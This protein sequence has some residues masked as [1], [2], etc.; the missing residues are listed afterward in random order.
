VVLSTHDP[1]HAFSVGNRVV[2]LDGGRL[3]AQGTP[4]EV[5]TPERLRAVYGVPVVVERLSQ[6]QTVCAP[7]YGATA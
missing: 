3:V 4:H 6:G 5:L 7:D 1:D 2:L